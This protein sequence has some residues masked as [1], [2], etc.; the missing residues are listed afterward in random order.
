MLWRTVSRTGYCRGAVVAYMYQDSKGE[1]VDLS[2]CSVFHRVTRQSI[3]ASGRWGTF[4]WNNTEALRWLAENTEPW[5]SEAG[6]PA[7]QHSD[8][9]APQATRVLRDWESKGKD[10]VFPAIEDP[11]DQ[12]ANDG[13]CVAVEGSH[14]GFTSPAGSSED[15]QASSIYQHPLR[16]PV[17]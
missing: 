2:R 1:V 15:P 9:C 8:A 12:K 10:S 3:R 6:Q 7:R 4:E 17:R 5:E 13:V 14:P 16:N 11:T